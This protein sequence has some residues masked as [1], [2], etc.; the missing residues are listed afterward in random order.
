MKEKCPR[1][2]Q[3]IRK[4]K[5]VLCLDCF[6]HLTPI[7][8]EWVWTLAQETLEPW[9][10]RQA[11][12]GLPWE[13]TVMLSRADLPLLLLEDPTLYQFLPSTSG[14]ASPQG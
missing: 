8:R 4:P 5:W 14:N 7:A 11:L 3:P 9:Q 2:E 10:A 12:R 13:R 1:C 6:A